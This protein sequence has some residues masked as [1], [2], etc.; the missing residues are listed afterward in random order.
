VTDD[1]LS[2]LCVACGF[3]CDGTLFSVVTVAPGEAEARAALAPR[4]RADGS[5]AAPMPCSQLEP[6]GCRLYAHRPKTCRAYE[7][8][9][10]KALGEQE[11]SLEAA[12]QTVTKARALVAEV[13]RLEGQGRGAMVRLRRAPPSE[14]GA[15]RDAFTAA[16]TFLRFHFLGQQRR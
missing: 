5:L 13:E 7:C 10:F 6:T 1:A 12:L 3:C 4:P 15:L 2:R 14:A 8:L 16:E 11:T 9:L